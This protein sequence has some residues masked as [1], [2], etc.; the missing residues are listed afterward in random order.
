MLLRTYIHMMFDYTM[1]QFVQPPK[2]A[3]ILIAHVWLYSQQYKN[4][5]KPCQQKKNTYSQI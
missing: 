5:A 3:F 4:E 1:C 2:T